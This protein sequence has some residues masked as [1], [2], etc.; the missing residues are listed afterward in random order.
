MLDLGFLG[1]LTCW[2]SAVGLRLLRGFGP[3]PEHPN[4]ALAFAVPLGLGSLA[5]AV[6]GLGEFGLLT[7]AGLGAVLILGAFVGDWRALGKRIADRGAWRTGRR[8]LGGSIVRL[9]TVADLARHAP[10][11]PRARHRRRCALLPSAGAEDLSGAPR[12]AVRAGPARDGLSAGHGDALRRGPGGPGAGGV[13]AGTVAFRSLFRRERD[14]PGAAVARRSGAL[15]GDDRLAGPGD[16]QRHGRSAER[17]GP[18]RVRQRDAPRLDALAGPPHPWARG[19][20][21][22]ARRAGPRREIPGAGADRNADP[23]HARDSPTTR[24]VLPRLGRDLRHDG[25]FDRRLLVPPR[26]RAYRKPRLSL[27]PSHVRRR[28]DRRRARPDQAADGRHA[29]QPAHFPGLDDPPAR[30]FRQLFPPVRPDLPAIPARPVPAPSAKARGGDRRPGVRLPVDLF[31]AAS[32]HAFRPDR[33]RPL[34]GRRG[35]GGVGLVGCAR[36][37]PR[38]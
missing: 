28:G 32:E 11:G 10:D 37:F 27:L 5:L 20:G 36:P 23:A 22:N 8:R 14:G 33:R 16:F 3:P 35:V 13:P 9:Y 15:G 34:G 2:A 12:D 7:R 26:L 6:L 25:S 38:G 17:R 31:N 29:A 4:D 1:L 24:A 21:R 18:R 30:S 19:P